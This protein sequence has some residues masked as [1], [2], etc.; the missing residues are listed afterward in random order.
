MECPGFDHHV[1]VC[2]VVAERFLPMAEAGLR[3][4][5]V[6]EEDIR[7]YLGIIEQ[8]CIRMQNGA[9]WQLGFIAKHGEDWLALV[10]EYD[11]WQRDG[12]PVHEWEL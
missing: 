4:L 6:D 1:P 12:R 3:Q 9:L 11:G 2:H 8:R 10:R 5:K 7:H